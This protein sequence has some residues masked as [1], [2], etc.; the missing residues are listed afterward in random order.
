MYASLRQSLLY[1]ETGANTGDSDDVGV[2][3]QGS[4]FGFDGNQSFGDFNGF[5]RIEVGFDSSEQD[6]SL[7]VR[8]GYVGI[9][10]AFGIVSI[11]SQWSA[12][13]TYVGS[14]HTNFVSEGDWQNGTGRNGSTLKYAG[15]IG[16]FAVE[17]DAVLIN[18]TDANPVSGLSANS[19]LLDEMQLAV[20]Y[21]SGNV[22]INAAL[23][24]RDGGA[25]GYLGGGSLMGA[26]ISYERG[27]MGLSFALAQ[28]DLS[29]RSEPELQPE[30]TLGMKF[31]AS[32]VKGA[33]SFLAVVTTAENEVA[34]NKPL[35]VALG[36]QHDLS[37]RSR[38][39]L[40]MSSVDP[41]IAGLDSS[42]EGGVMYR[43]DW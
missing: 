11:G 28:D 25:D 31:R 7:G 3:D 9:S 36:Y 23:I 22:T 4:R 39:A 10:G 43:H 5:G 41:D 33:N 29:F 32:Y 17:V 1:T 2:V 15:R 38:V 8:L 18:Q 37:Q 19:G 34:A 20:G 12:W 27:A 40:E 24:E 35:T 21:T 26:R 30:E 6:D 13:D 16:D 42:I 14:S